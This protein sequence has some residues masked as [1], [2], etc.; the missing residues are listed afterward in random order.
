MKKMNDLEIMASRIMK[1]RVNHLEDIVEEYGSVP[2]SDVIDSSFDGGIDFSLAKEIS[3]LKGKGL[4]TLMDDY[5]EN[6]EKFEKESLHLLEQFVRENKEVMDK[7]VAEVRQ[8]PFYPYSEYEAVRVEKEHLYEKENLPKLME[9]CLTFTAGKLLTNELQEGNDFSK[10][11]FANIRDCQKAYDA[12][13]RLYEQ[14]EMSLANGKEENLQVSKSIQRYLDYE[15]K[16]GRGETG[17]VSFRGETVKD[18]LESIGNKEANAIKTLKDLNQALKECGIAPIRSL[19]KENTK[20]ANENTND[21]S[22]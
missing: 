15:L 3:H 21:F 4:D 6:H 2:V 20:K 8:H 19:K 18:F 16:D 10:G 13:Q 1:R 14:S 7:T 5:I 11:K 9:E 12:V 22:K 17:G